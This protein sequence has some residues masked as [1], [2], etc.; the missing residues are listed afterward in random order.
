VSTAAWEA[1]R[2]LN[3]AWRMPLFRRRRGAA[4]PG[5][6]ARSLSDVAN[7]TAYFASPPCSAR[8]RESKAASM[9]PLALAGIAEKRRAPLCLVCAAQADGTRGAAG[10][11]DPTHRSAARAPANM[12][13]VPSE[14]VVSAAAAAVVSP[15]VAGRGRG[16]GGG[17]VATTARRAAAARA[18]G[19]GGRRAFPTGWWRPSHRDVPPLPPPP[20]PRRPLACP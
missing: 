15:V 2:R 16:G 18:A 17:A 5:P 4:A 9:D 10:R 12:D 14:A 3:K 1:A 19:R 11:G 13:A 6:G 8:R 7:W 20:S